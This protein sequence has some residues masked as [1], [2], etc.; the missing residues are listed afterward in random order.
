MFKNLIVYRVGPDWQPDLMVAMESLAKD[1][2]VPCSASQPNSIGWVPPRGVEHAPLVESIGGQWLMKL[3]IEQK[4]L[5][6]SVVK[7][8]A[9][10]I[11]AQI[12][13]TTGRKPGKKQGKELKEQATQELLP[14]A[15]T[16]LGATQVWLDPQRRLLMI[17]SGSAGRAEAVVTFLV[18]A[19]PGFAVLL[20]Q[21]QLSPAVA[22]AAWLTDGEAPAGFS[23]DRECELKSADEMKS[24]V[25]YARH[26]LDTEDVRQHIAQGKQP[27]RLALTW[28]GRISFVL[29]DALQLKKLA[30][31]DVVFE[32]LQGA[33]DSREEAFDTD[34]AIATGE[35]CQ[36]IPDLIEALDGEL[37][38]GSLP[39]ALAA[40]PEASVP[41]SAVGL[42]D[43][44]AAD[45]EPPP[46][47]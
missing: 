25:R 29:T 26:A 38:P 43:S 14:M 33:A 46:W 8:R 24:V 44:G 1:G 31:D 42:P 22:M 4:V 3:M 34:A 39:A 19:L 35:L 6:A 12:E 45:T 32:G 16:K 15:F 41:V 13:Q 2:F 9:D 17:D 20:L 36:L 11:A 40:A 28:Q 18:K 10:E 23:V 27:T 5:P 37:Q 47:E 7:R 30:F 21:T